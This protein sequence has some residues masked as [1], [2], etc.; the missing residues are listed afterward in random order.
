MVTLIRVNE[1]LHRRQIE[2]AAIK[3]FDVQ[4]RTIVF[5]ALNELQI[6]QRQLAAGTARAESFLLVVAGRQ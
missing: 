3:C 6:R 5:P 1:R 4:L 2:H